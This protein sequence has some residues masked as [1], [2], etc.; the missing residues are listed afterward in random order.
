MQVVPS[1][2][3]RATYRRVASDVRRRGVSGSPFPIEAESI[4]FLDGTVPTARMTRDDYLTAEVAR[5]LS[6][7]ALEKAAHSTQP[8]VMVRRAER[9][10]GITS[11]VVAVLDGIDEERAL[12]DLTTRKMAN[13]VVQLSRR[14]KGLSKEDALTSSLSFYL[15]QGI[16]ADQAN[17]SSEYRHGYRKLLGQ[18]MASAQRL[19]LAGWLSDAWDKTK[20]AAKQ[21]ADYVT[22]KA[23]QAAN[24]VSEKAKAVANFDPVGAV[25]D[26]VIGWLQDRLKEM[27]GFLCKVFKVILGGTV[28][29][30]VCALMDK[31]LKIGSLIIGTVISILKD[32]LTGLIR[33]VIAILDGRI[34]EA[35]KVLASTLNLML[36]KSLV[37]S[38]AISPLAFLSDFAN[39]PALKSQEKPG[40]LMSIETL[41]ERVNTRSPLFVINV[42]LSVVGL[43]GAVANPKLAVGALI[44]AFSPAVAVLFA[45][46][47]KK[48]LIAIDAKKYRGVTDESC[49]NGLDAVVTLTTAVVVA[50]M[51]LKDFYDKL[52]SKF[53]QQEAASTG[54]T[55]KAQTAW[56]KIGGQVQTGLKTVVKAFFA[57][58]LGGAGQAILALLPYVAVVVLALGTEVDAATFDSIANETFKATDSALVPVGTSYQALTTS[59]ETIAASAPPETQAAASDDAH[60]R[61]CAEC[62]KVG[63]TCQGCDDATATGT[64]GK[65]GTTG[66][67]GKTGK[68]PP[69][70]PKP[71]AA[72]PKIGFIVAGGLGIA[73]V[74]MLFTRKKA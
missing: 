35:L 25:F 46:D 70:P 6:F 47:Y 12:A 59:W 8:S 3:N 29:G 26:Q 42:A 45:A 39:R 51:T 11:K 72:A 58:K 24:Y 71:P 64:T 16:A 23:E 33:F 31:L 27:T 28:G 13:D 15:L 34:V 73:A 41:A 9:L 53:Q 50:A 52:K 1:L 20:S 62:R 7:P 2:G 21:A 54:S 18:T 48:I 43:V 68:P 17:E 22:D 44:I 32:L 4:P 10:A 36:F 49:E 5:R 74:I 14:L 38:A 55:A 66:T 61:A 19:Q 30:W 65:T 67:T 69:K 57:F 40:G 56:A 60:K 63:K 37:V